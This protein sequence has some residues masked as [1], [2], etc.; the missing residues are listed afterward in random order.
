[1][2]QSTSTLLGRTVFALCVALLSFGH[3]AQGQIYSDFGA[4]P[5]PLYDSGSGWLVS[6]SASPY[7]ASA[8]AM[9][10]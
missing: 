2:S 8:D 5:A 3:T 10:F 7:G 6:G 9:A 4:P 1:M